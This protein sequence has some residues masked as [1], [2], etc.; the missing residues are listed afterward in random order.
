MFQ[1][2]RRPRRQKNATIKI[3]IPS[4]RTEAGSGNCA[5]SVVPF[6][7]VASHLP[8]IVPSK[9]ELN[10][11]FTTLLRTKLTVP[12]EAGLKPPPLVVGLVRRFSWEFVRLAAK[13][14][15]ASAL[16][17]ATNMKKKTSCTMRIRSIHTPPQ[18]PGTNSTAI[19]ELSLILFG[20]PHRCQGGAKKFRKS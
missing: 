2:L 18:G 15:M 13:I 17:T 9:P 3:P 4:K 16:V 7:F 10:G 14:G 1:R 11:V 19:F 5:T 6:P 20:D 12:K 8:R